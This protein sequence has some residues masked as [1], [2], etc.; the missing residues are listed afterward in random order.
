MELR[1]L[2]ESPETTHVTWRGDIFLSG[3]FL[4]SVLV[5]LCVRRGDVC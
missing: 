1:N 5:V 3:E 2:V 4:L